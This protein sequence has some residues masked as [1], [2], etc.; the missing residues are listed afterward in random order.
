MICVAAD[1]RQRIEEALLG[2]QN[3]PEWNKTLAGFSVTGFRSISFDDYLEAI[4]IL[5]ATKSLS[6]GITYY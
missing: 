2:L 3:K 5:E 1:T 6:F 4:D